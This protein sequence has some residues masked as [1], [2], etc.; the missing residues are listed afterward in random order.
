MAKIKLIFPSA[1]EV[2]A[3]LETEVEPELAAD[4]WERVAVPQRGICNVTVSTGDSFGVNLRPL[5]EA[6]ESSGTLRAPI[7]NKPLFYTEL[8]PGNILWSRARAYVCYGRCTEPGIVGAKVAQV[9]PEYMKTFRK[10]CEEIRNHTFFYHEMAI[11]TIER[12][13]A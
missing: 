9:E 13:D 2:Y 7:G 12:G 5:R 6:P 11:V 3:T 4:L 1:V 10:E 8:R